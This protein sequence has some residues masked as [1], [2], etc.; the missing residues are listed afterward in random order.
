MLKTASSI[1]PDMI[2]AVS[3]SR[4]SWMWWTMLCRRTRRSLRWRSLSFR[5]VA[6]SSTRSFISSMTCSS[7]WRTSSPVVL[8]EVAGMIVIWR[9]M[10]KIGTRR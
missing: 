1:V 3:S 6:E 5:S 8:Y 7:A 2:D 10:M 9:M 4:R